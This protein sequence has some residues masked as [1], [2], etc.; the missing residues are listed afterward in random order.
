MNTNNIDVR[1][2]RFGK[3]T[4]YH[5]KDGYGFIAP[6]GGGKD[7]HFRV[8]A[9]R[10]IVVGDQGPAFGFGRI[11]VPHTGALV[12][13]VL[14]PN[15]SSI[16]EWGYKFYYEGAKQRAS[17]TPF[18]RL[19]RRDS[20]RNE[21][22]ERPLKPVFGGAMLPALIKQLQAGQVVYRS[23]TVEGPMTTVQWFQERQADGKF[24]DVKNELTLATLAAYDKSDRARALAA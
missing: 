3:V 23:T 2:I 4:F 11:P 13:F 6:D 10:R 7:I 14:P 18:I 12:V 19:V 20:F 9:G 22:G 15:M 16:S 21:L 17:Q 8:E 1:N 24:D 5:P